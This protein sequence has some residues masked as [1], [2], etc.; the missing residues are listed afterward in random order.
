MLFPF[1]WFAGAADAPSAIPDELAGAWVSPAY[2]KKLRATRSQQEADRSGYTPGQPYAVG[3]L[4]R[5]G[6]DWLRVWYNF[7]DSSGTDCA[8]AEVKR[9]P[10]GTLLP[11]CT[12]GSGRGVLTLVRS[13]ATV[14]ALEWSAPQVTLSGTR[15]YKVDGTYLPAWTTLDRY[16]ATA[17][18]GGR[19]TDE[20]GRRVEFG[21]DGRATWN[22]KEYAFEVELDCW[23]GGCDTLS[24]TPAEGGDVLE[25][26]FV[27]KESRLLLH[28]ADDDGP[29][30]LAHTLTPAR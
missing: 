7:H 24:L 28:E 12:D 21:R 19:Y 30:E 25:W 18:V 29:G 13:S 20:K 6:A 8:L 27:W 4:R 9:R 3:F 17:T 23:D 14:K 10:D 2:A 22:G 1:A 16:V 15:S 26:N 5:D 11:F